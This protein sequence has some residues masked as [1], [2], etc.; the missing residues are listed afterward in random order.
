MEDEEHMAYSEALPETQYAVQLVGPGRLVLNQHKQV[1]EPAP[2]ELLVRVEAV[3]LCYSDVKLAK[4]FSAHPRKGEIVS[5]IGRDLLERCRSYVPGEKPGVPGHEV[6]CRVVAVGSEVQRYRVGERF[7]VQTDYRSLLTN[8]SNAAF[9][10]TFEGG[11]Q[12][13]VLL[14]E[15]VTIEPGTGERY[16]VSAPESLAASAIALIEPWSCVEN[17]YGSADRRSIRAGGRLLVVADGGL[18]LLGL[19]GSF[20]LEGGPASMVAVIAEAAQRTALEGMGVPVTFAGGLDSLPDE[21]FDDIVYFGADK[22]T[23]EVLNDKLAYG[24]VANVVLGGKT[25]ASRVSI[26]VGRVHYG[27]TRWVGTPGTSAAASYAAV[28]SS[29]ELRAHDRVLVTGAAGPMGQMHVIRA[30]CSGVEGISV[31]AADIDDA[32]LEVLRRKAEP[33]AKRTGV[34]L[35]LVNTATEP[36]EGRF[37]Y[38]VILVPSGPLVASAIDAA[39]DGGLVDIF[40]GIPAATR[41]EVDLDGYIRRRCYMFGTSGSVLRDMRTLLAKVTS[42]QLDTNCSVDAVAGIAGAIDGLE[43]VEKQTL[44]GKVV[45]YPALRDLGLVALA[46]LGQHFPTVRSKLDNGQWTLAAEQELLQVAGKGAGNATWP[47]AGPAAAQL[48]EAY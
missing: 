24:G 26:G 20:G 9:G 23:I 35:R 43:A 28:P 48:G 7:L 37:S 30:L 10:Y 1:P 5:G 31:V 42:G 41:Q 15:R 45:V 4:Q 19:A 6:A 22:R 38:Q 46:D 34:P 17:A 36:L 39:T 2:H 8:G 11:L 25:I 40:A 18:E 44:A 47:E 29:G 32:R 27:L 12:E 33:Y 16:M 13:Y 21:S 14:D 3:G